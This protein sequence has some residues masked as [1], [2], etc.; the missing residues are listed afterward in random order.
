[1]GDVDDDNGSGGFAGVPVQI[2]EVSKAASKVVVTVKDCAKN[3]I[4]SEN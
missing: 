1:M 2:G 4:R 3:L